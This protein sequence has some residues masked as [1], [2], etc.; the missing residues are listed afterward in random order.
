ML[1]EFILGLPP[2]PSCVLLLCSR[3][4][5]L[6][7]KLDSPAESNCYLFLLHLAAEMLCFGNL[8][9]ILAWSCA[10]LLCPC[11][12]FVNPLW[13]SVPS[14]KNLAASAFTLFNVDET[15]FWCEILSAISEQQSKTF[16]QSVEMLILTISL[17]GLVSRIFHALRH[18]PILHSLIWPSNIFLYQLRL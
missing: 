16:A 10:R 3:A 11:W 12:A 6:A 8:F 15:L 14:L 17:C 9:L 13:T 7:L 5:Q 1:W 18:P 2:V 4:K